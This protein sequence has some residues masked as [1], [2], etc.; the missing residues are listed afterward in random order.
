M[1]EHIYPGTN[2]GRVVIIRPREAGRPVGANG[3]RSRCGTPSA[4]SGT[5]R[6]KMAQ[7]CCELSCV[8]DA[9][10][11][12]CSSF[13]PVRMSPA[14]HLPHSGVDVDVVCVRKR[15]QPG[16]KFS[17]VFGSWAKHLAAESTLLPP[18][19]LME[20]WR[21]WKLLRNP[22]PPM[23]SFVLYIFFGKVVGF[24]DLA[25]LFGD[26]VHVPHP[27]DGGKKLMLLTM[28]FKF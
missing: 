4:T 8:Y 6:T 18:K 17:H 22:S 21:A 1:G 13:K 23:L 7:M 11:T 27:G 16:S 9:E 15:Q 5:R 25:K 24:P 3:S 19:E 10:E 20:E 12:V 28:L 14:D 2:E 26:N